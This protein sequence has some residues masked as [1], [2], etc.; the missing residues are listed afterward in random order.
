MHRCL[1]V[2]H[3][4]FSCLSEAELSP[5]YTSLNHGRPY[6]LLTREKRCLLLVSSVA[7]FDL[8]YEIIFDVMGSH[9]ERYYHRTM[10]LI[11]HELWAHWPKP[12]RLHY[13]SDLLLRHPFLC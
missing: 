9:L 7:F 1:P 2:L 10:W 4:V 8:N 12:K 3:R 6:Y 13:A 5:F 11:L